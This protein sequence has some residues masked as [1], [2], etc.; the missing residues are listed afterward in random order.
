MLLSPA[1]EAA[2]LI[3]RLDR[4][5]RSGEA[6]H[7]LNPAQWEALRYL[8]RA[9][10][11]SRTP[12]A[13]AD[14]LGSTRGTVSQSLISLEE[15]GHIARTPSSRDKRSVDLSLTALGEAALGADPLLRLTADMAAS[16][17]EDLTAAVMLLRDTL[18]RALAR[19]GGKPF[20]VCQTCRYFE[21]LPESEAGDARCA[22]LGEPLSKQD[23]L[24]ICVEQMPVSPVP[25]P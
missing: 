2:Q 9:N 22:L 7:G 19:N 16:D 4:L 6:A 13:L 5:V 3:D 17:P 15:K 20:G 18:S 24:A 1:V 8:S 25:V 12:A 23:A 11:F 14:Y 10:R 21:A